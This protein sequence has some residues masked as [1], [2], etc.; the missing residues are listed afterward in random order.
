[1][2]QTILGLDIGSY[3]VKVATLQAS[4][5]SISLTSLDEFI[6]PHAGRSRPERAA[7][8]VLESLAVQS[9]EKDAVVVA[10]LPGDRVMTR[11][12]EL[13]FDDPK[14][15]ESVLGFELEGLLPLTV[16]EMVYAYQPNGKMA[17]GEYQ[18]FAAATQPDTIKNY[19]ESLADSGVDPRVLT[20]DTTCFMNLYD[21]V[22][23]DEETIAFI[24][25]GHRTTKICVVAAGQLR[26]ARSLGRGGMSI[27]EAISEV[28]DV[29]IE[30]AERIK[31]ESGALPFASEQ[32]TPIGSAAQKALRPLVVGLRQSL[33]AYA[34]ENDVPVGRIFLA[35]GG[36]RLK[37]IHPWLEKKLGL[38]V[39]AFDVGKLSFNSV[40]NDSVTVGAKAIGLGLVQAQVTKHVANLNFRRG[41]FGYEGDFQFVRERIRSLAVMAAVLLVVASGYAVLKSNTLDQ[42]LAAQ[43]EA[44]AKFTK[45]NLGK[46]QTS[47]AKTVKI[48]K[49]GPSDDS[50]VD[51]FPPM[52]AIMVLDK[53]TQAQDD[54]NRGMKAGGPGPAGAPK[55]GMERRTA[56]VR[57]PLRNRPGAISGPRVDPAKFAT[58]PLANPGNSKP[59]VIPKIDDNMPGSE[60]ASTKAVNGTVDKKSNETGDEKRVSDQRKIELSMVNID[61]Y[62]LVTVTAETHES[63]VGGKEEFRKR[64]E[65]ES[66]FTNVKRKDMGEVVSTGRHSD[67]VRFQVTFS[68][69]CPKA[70]A[71]TA[72][73]TTTKKTKDSGGDK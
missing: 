37:N 3:S 2:A 42:Q 52:T 39:H 43:K 7:S 53:V 28:L 19:L 40:A 26:L 63:N 65:K 55:P 20:L 48:L 64:L 10:A 45:E 15:I 18:V 34:R 41:Q 49:R 14:R 31:H 46:K 29:D 70:D 25:I 73:D 56:P 47:F 30:E 17:S 16:G 67:W 27:T 23:S 61:V 69:K 21:H 51:L 71:D 6:I 36:A 50:Q 8:D 54:Q 72:S 12:V 60:P 5:R 35:G 13:P 59:P 38:P 1:M 44:L 24:D 4:F 58:Q 33:Q 57:R 68:V 11:F 62:K 22:A 32:P 66:C 9:K